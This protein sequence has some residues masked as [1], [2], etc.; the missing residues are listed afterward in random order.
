[1]NEL[2]STTY[3]SIPGTH[4]TVVR[5]AMLLEATARMLRTKC[6]THEDALV[7]AEGL[8]SRAE[9]LR[10]GAPQTTVLVERLKALAL[11]ARETFR[12]ELAS[13]CRRH[14]PPPGACGI[15]GSAPCKMW[16]E[17]ELDGLRDEVASLRSELRLAIGESGRWDEAWCELYCK[18]QTRFADSVKRGTEH[19][20]GWYDAFDFMESLMESMKPGVPHSRGRG[21]TMTARKTEAGQP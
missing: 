19:A 12:A 5:A 9:M 8:S 16:D 13:E 17:C 21:D 7:T 15:C 10:S 11:R 14:A 18:V 1:M 4:P 2:T 20:D 3:R 6:S